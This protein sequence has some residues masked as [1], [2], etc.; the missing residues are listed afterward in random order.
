ML[1]EGYRSAPARLELSGEIAALTTKYDT[2]DGAIAD[3]TEEDVKEIFRTAYIDLAKDTIVLRRGGDMAA[4]AVL[5]PHGPHERVVAFGVVDPDHRGRGLGAYLFDFI[6]Q[7]ALELRRA[8][9]EEL[10]LHYF[11]DVTDDAAGD[12][13]DKR[14]FVRIRD[15]YTMYVEFG[16]ERPSKDVP[17]WLT[18]KTCTP[19]DKHLCY[20][21]VEETFADHFGHVKEPYEEWERGLPARADYDPT[22]WWLAFDGDEPAGLLLAFQMEHMGYVSDLGVRNAYRNRGI[23]ATLLRHAFAEFQHRGVGAVG[24]GVDAQNETGAVRLY[25]NVGMHAVRHYGTFEKRYFR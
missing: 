4:Y 1:P 15:H 16:D 19:E 18:I 12:M 8:R 14:G 9:D 20:E 2:R 25:E 5:W 22:L 11:L 24:L 23:A 6:E 17:D 21:L 10:L 13:A 7:G 3:F